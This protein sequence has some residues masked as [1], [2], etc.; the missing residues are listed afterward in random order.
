MACLQ[1]Y[2]GGEIR[3]E[4]AYPGE[5]A[6]ATSLP[7]REPSSQRLLIAR[8]CLPTLSGVVYGKRGTRI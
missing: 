4:F 6:Y 7:S 5:A 8:T 3:D 2:D 1:V